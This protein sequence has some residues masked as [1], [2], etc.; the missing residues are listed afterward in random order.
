MVWVNLCMRDSP[1]DR[2]AY[3][4]VEQ[5]RDDAVDV[6]SAAIPQPVFGGLGARV[7]LDFGLPFF[8][9]A[10]LDRADQSGVGKGRKTGISRDLKP[11]RHA[12]RRDLKEMRRVALKR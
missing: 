7:V 8:A 9:R 1:A 11:G 5:A 3:R 6:F 4:A 2:Q 10:K 12:R